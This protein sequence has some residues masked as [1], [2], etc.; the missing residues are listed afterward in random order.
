[1]Q[2]PHDNWADHY[3]FVY[4]NTYPFSFYDNFTNTTI[5]AIGEI[6]KKGTII[7][8]GAGTGRLSI[9]LKQLGYEIT[10]V[11][12]SS[13]MYN[14]LLD[15]A[16]EQGLNIPVY[17]CSI[18]E[19]QND[20]CNLAICLFTVLSYVISEE[21]M[22][23]TVDNI[24][25]KLDSGGY[26]F[27]DLPGNVFFN[28]NPLINVQKVNLKRLVTLT[29]Q[30]NRDIYTYTEICSGSYN[31]NPFQ[32]EDEFPIKKWNIE[33]I[34]KLLEERKVYKA[35]DNFPQF[36]NTGSNYYLYRKK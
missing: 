19:Y 32:Y 7:D 21:E 4:E 20:S 3:D 25:D 26:F 29:P 36:A 10:A 33:D 17:N 2:Q 30:V 14:R 18:S 12:K 1:M 11:E 16:N 27:F 15:K 31:G 6:L 22:I 9:P 34:N 28:T 35:N 23:A 24:C 8:Y 13:G 5:S